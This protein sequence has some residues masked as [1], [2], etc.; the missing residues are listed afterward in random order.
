MS[1]HRNN[2]D[3]VYLFCGN[4]STQFARLQ[5]CQRT[6]GSKKL[7][8]HSSTVLDSLD[9]DLQSGLKRRQK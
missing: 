5:R 6:K 3:V 1:K 7:V 2:W 9:K 4:V 8:S